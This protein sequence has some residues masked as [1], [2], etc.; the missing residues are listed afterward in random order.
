MQRESFTGS[1]ADIF[2]RTWNFIGQYFLDWERS[3]SAAG[4]DKQ[5]IWEYI[6][7][8]EKEDQ[9]PEPATSADRAPL[10]G[11]R[12]GAVASATQDSRFERLKILKPAALP[13]DTYFSIELSPDPDE[14]APA[15]QAAERSSDGEHAGTANGRRR[16]RL[17]RA[18]RRVNLAEGRQE[19]LTGLVVGAAE[20]LSVKA[21]LA[22]LGRFAPLGS[23]TL[24]TRSP[25]RGERKHAFDR[26]KPSYAEALAVL[27]PAEGTS[28]NETPTG[29]TALSQRLF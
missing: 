29:V 22:D 18:E 17:P 2:G 9:R 1:C 20:R 15:I 27:G 6:K 16:A 26:S 13:G 3:V 12:H 28:Q 25:F 8:G 5:L 24:P 7:N 11:P 21:R 10:G 19:M 4:R 23:S 14:L